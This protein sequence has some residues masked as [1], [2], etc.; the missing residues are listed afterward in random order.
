MTLLQNTIRSR[1]AGRWGMAGAGLGVLGGLVTAFLPASVSADRF[2]FPY[3]PAGF[4][5][6]EVSFAVSHL[7]V[8][9]CVLGLA[10]SGAL[11]RSLSGRIG[12]WA[13]SAGW[14]GL[15]VCEFVAMTFLNSVYPTAQTDRLD[16]AYGV[17]TL[18]IGAGMVAMGI[19]V[20]R[21]G[22]WT[23]WRRYI[24]LACGAAVFLLVLPTVF[25]GNFTLGRLVLVV[26]LLML[27]VL[28][29]A[30]ATTRPAEAT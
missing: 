2:S 25:S 19:G 1:S 15:T 18:L 16:A 24:T 29:Y 22:V 26:W 27:G 5:V 10:R 4:V 30:L 12:T 3:T 6:A 28:G 11:G 13:A 8:L 9:I 20:L 23:R 7:L 21:A 14:A 17:S